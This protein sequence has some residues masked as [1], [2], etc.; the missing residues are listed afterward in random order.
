MAISHLEGHRGQTGC[1]ILAEWQSWR[2]IGNAIILSLRRKSVAWRGPLEAWLGLQALGCQ[3]DWWPL[4]YSS[5]GPGGALPWPSL[6]GA[7]KPQSAVYGCSVLGRP[8]S[9]PRPLPSQWPVWMWNCSPN[10]AASLSCLGALKG[11]HPVILTLGTYPSC[12]FSV[13]VAEA[14]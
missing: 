1:F 12:C 13:Y 11:M 7:F 10:A 2:H 4:L 8:V 6:K 14:P 5:A 3:A 9:L